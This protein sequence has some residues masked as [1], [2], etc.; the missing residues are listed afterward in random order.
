MY[1]CAAIFP[2][3]LTRMPFAPCVPTSSPRMRSSA[4][5]LDET[6]LEED[7]PNERSYETN[8]GSCDDEFV[9][10]GQSQIA[11]R[12]HCA[13]SEPSDLSGG[14]YLLDDHR[15]PPHQWIG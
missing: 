8:A 10:R 7:Q 14:R 11:Q 12:R 3:A 2:C 15:S 1:C 4:I 5:G 9:Q 13:R 6:D